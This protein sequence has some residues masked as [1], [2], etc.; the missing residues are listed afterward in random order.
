MAEN[1]YRSIQRIGL[2][3]ALVYALDTETYQHLTG[4][5]VPSVDGS[6]NLD[7][8]NRTRVQRHI[9]R[10]EAERHMAAAA[11]AASGLDVLLTDSSH[12]II[13]DITLALHDVAKEG[14]VDTA[15]PRGNCN[16]RP[17]IGCSPWWNLVFLR[18]AG[19]PEQRNRAVEFQVA[20][21]RKGMVDCVPPIKLANPSVLG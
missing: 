7:A 3:N 17:P 19:T 4:R 6:T 20:G 8:W 15:V 10:A 11:L 12:V 2:L 5:G 1:W 9:Q 16:G 18:G 13:G 14:V 21:V